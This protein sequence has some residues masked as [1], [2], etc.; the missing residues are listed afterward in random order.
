M[1]TCTH[2]TYVLVAHFT[3]VPENRRTRAN[4][5]GLGLNTQVYSGMKTYFLRDKTYEVEAS[6]QVV[7][8]LRQPS[9]Q[10]GMTNSV[11]V[12]ANIQ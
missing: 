7:A 10:L 8:K 2:S 4:R 3:L 9:S 12:L 6:T 5:L 1:Y 11:L